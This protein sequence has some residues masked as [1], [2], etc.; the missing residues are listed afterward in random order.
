MTKIM[1]TTIQEDAIWYMYWNIPYRTVEIKNGFKL[2]WIRR[3]NKSGN[4]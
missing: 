1:T 3:K 2:N 4:S